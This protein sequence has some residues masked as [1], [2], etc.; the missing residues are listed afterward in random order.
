MTLNFSIGKNPVLDCD[1]S[2]W[3]EAS[4][5]QF[6]KEA[7]ELGRVTRTGGA[8]ISTV[9]IYHDADAD[10]DALRTALTDLAN[11]ILPGNDFKC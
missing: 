3:P 9:R 10:L 2:G 6:Q 4:R 8:G 1:C 5:Q 11:T 7:R